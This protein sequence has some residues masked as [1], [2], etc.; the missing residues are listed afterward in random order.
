MTASVAADPFGERK[1]AR[2]RARLTVLG[3]DFAI[4]S[5]DDAL[6]ELVVEAFGQLPR[7]RLDGKACRLK[8]SLVLTAQ[9]RTWPRNSEPPRPVLSAGNGLLCATIDAGNFV[10]VDPSMSR[11]LVCVSRAMLRHRYHA[12][13]ELIEL[14]LVT[15]A[16]RAQSLVP[17]H[18]ACFG[19]SGSGLLVMGGSGTGKSTLALHAFARGMQLLSEDSAFVD[20]ATRLIVGAPNYLHIA[21][22]ALEHLEPGTL[23][24]RLRRSP[25]IRRR[26][27]AR[28]LEVDLRDAP[29]RLARAP[30]RLTATIFLSR[31]R[32]GRQP[33]VRPL[34][35]E[36]GLN[37]L[38]REQVYARG[39]PNW[40]E[41]ERLIADLPC[42]ELRRTEHPD[43]AVRELGNILSGSTEAS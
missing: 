23:E 35:Q 38:R 42:F 22:S 41:F 1:A 28:K 15:L 7:Y 3:A 5:T 13:Y 37:R 43:L 20:L 4:E 17:L 32:A 34:A 11:T 2:F 8:V 30:L 25:V 33:A 29:G 6:L 27:G 31:R 36:S 16:S 14:A 39:M 9:G 24:Q 10:V 18:A 19:S 40:C 12:R 21:R 26:S